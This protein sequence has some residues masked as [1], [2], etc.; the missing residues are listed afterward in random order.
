MLI[1][2]FS[3]ASFLKPDVEK[4]CGLGIAR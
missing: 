1:R 2:L 4:S 3:Q